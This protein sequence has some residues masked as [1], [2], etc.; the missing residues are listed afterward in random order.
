MFPY[1]LFNISRK[2]PT[3]ERRY[4]MYFEVDSPIVRWLALSLIMIEHLPFLDVRRYTAG[5][6]R[7]NYPY[8]A[9]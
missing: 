8:I 3:K 5:S 2:T 9:G 6:N 1:M 7:G 4:C